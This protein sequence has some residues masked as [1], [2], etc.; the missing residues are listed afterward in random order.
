MSCEY[1]T[2]SSGANRMAKSMTLEAQLS[3]LRE[4]EHAAL[5]PELRE[6]LCAALGGTNNIVTARA[7]QVMASSG[8]AGFIPHLVAAFRHLLA[9]PAAAD[10]NCRAKEAILLALDALG[11]YEEEAPL[12][13]LRYVQM[14]PVYGGRTDT[15]V[16]LRAAC[17]AA[18]A[19]MHYSEA[20]LDS[21]G[22]WSTRRRRRASP[23]C[24][25]WPFSAMSAA[26]CC[27]A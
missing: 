17:A 25:R 27:C 4:I 12:L 24:R 11:S 13:G 21:P 10:K 2:N 18:L 15:A 6:E 5:T 23:P 3:R 1:L 26:S 7:A 19:R 14:E 20:H 16:N 9:Q 22:C 8:H